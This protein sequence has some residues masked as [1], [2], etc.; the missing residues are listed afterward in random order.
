VGGVMDEYIEMGGDEFEVIVALLEELSD[1]GV[2]WDDLLNLTLLASAYCGQMAE[3]S[4]EEY[5][6]II[7]SIRVTE[8]GI[9]GEA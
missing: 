4:P 2:E 1:S 9:Y 3:M 6:Q 5:L 7:S 8:D